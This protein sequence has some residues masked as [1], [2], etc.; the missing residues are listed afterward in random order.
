LCDFISKIF[1][2]SIILFSIMTIIFQNNI[3][4]QE[5][6]QEKDYQH[7]KQEVLDVSDAERNKMIQDFLVNWIKNEDNLYEIKQIFQR[8]VNMVFATTDANRNKLAQNFF[9]NNYVIK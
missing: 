3:F 1:F 9:S 5:Q 8:R 2:F 6:E 4:A 7:F